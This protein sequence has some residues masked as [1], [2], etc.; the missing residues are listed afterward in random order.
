MDQCC[1]NRV[2]QH[3]VAAEDAAAAHV[4]H[5]VL[6][7]SFVLVGYLHQSAAREKVAI[8]TFAQTSV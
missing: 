7:F 2:L 6:L 4:V 1:R 8:S 5:C 3:V